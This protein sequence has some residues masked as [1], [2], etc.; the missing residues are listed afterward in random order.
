MNTISV[1][2]HAAP[3]SVLL[4][5]FLTSVAVNAQEDPALVEK[6]LAQ[7]MATY[8]GELCDWER[9]RSDSSQIASHTL[10]FRYDYQQEGEPDNTVMLYEMPCYYGAY[11]F[12]SIWFLETEYDGLLP[13]HFAEP[14]LDVKY[15]DDENT[16]VESIDIVGFSTAATLVNAFYDEAAQSISA[17]AKWRGVADAS[18][19]GTWTFRQGEFVLTRYEVDASYDGEINPVTVYDSSQH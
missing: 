10:T 17:F 3:F 4:S 15:S 9:V 16:I 5:I 1:W 7:G 14:E 11:N 18:S 6:M 12:S 19:T 13:L 2:R 8:P